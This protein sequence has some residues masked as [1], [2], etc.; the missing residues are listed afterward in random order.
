VRPY[1]TLDLRRV[2]RSGAGL[3]G[4]FRGV[5][6]GEERCEAMLIRLSVVEVDAMSEAFVQVVVRVE[7]LVANLKGHFDSTTE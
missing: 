7:H 1:P 5:S 2:V 3:V 4:P 6:V